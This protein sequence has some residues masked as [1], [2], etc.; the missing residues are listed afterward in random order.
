MKDP[1][2]KNQWAVQSPGD[3]DDMCQ[4]VNILLNIIK[5]K[6]HMC[7]FKHAM[8]LNPDSFSIRN[9]KITTFSL[10]TCKRLSVLSLG[11]SYTKYKEK[12]QKTF[13]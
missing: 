1:F 7:G 9:P 8:S 3:G 6:K 11:E 2:G 5:K 12:Y 13:I 4:L 10:A